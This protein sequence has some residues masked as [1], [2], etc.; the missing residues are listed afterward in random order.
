[1]WKFILR[2]IIATTLVS[3]MRLGFVSAGADDWPQLG[4]DGSCNAVIAERPSPP[5]ER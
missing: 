5:A 4:R 1:M 3:D 2:L